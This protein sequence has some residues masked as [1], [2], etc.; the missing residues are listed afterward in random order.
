MKPTAAS[1]VIDRKGRTAADARQRRP[2][3]L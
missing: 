2:R 3:L 1:S